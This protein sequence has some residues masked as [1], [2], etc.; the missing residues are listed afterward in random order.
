MANALNTVNS[1]GIKDGEVKTA[2]ILDA[3]VTTAKLAGDAVTGAKIADDAIDSE[4]IK[5][6]AVDLAHMSSESVDEDNLH[7]SNAGSNGQY[8]QKQTGNSGG[9][10]W[11]T[12]DTSTLMPLAGGTFT[13]DVTFD[14]G[15]N[16]GKDITWDESDDALEFADSTKASFGAGNDLV[17]QHDGTNNYIDTNTGA[18][19]IRSIGSA[20][21]VQI[22]ADSDYMA[23][24]VNDGEV[25]LYHDNEAKIVTKA[26]GAIVQDL[27]ASGAYLDIKGSDGV[28]GKVY[29]VSGTTVGL[30]DDQNHY[31]IKGVKDGA[32]SLYYD[33]SVKLAT[34]S[35][36]GTL[37]GT[38]SGVGKILQVVTAEHSATTS[39]TGT[40]YVDTGLTADITP[41]SS[42]NKIMVI[43]SQSWYLDRGTDQAR[44]G[45]RLVR[46]STVI[47]EGPNQG[48]GSA[49]GGFGVSTAN[50]PSAIQTAGR[51]NLTMV[52]SPSTTSEITYHTEMANHQTGSSPTLTINKSL[53]NNGQ[54]GK[55]YIT[56]LEIAG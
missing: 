28:N 42:S 56:L 54:N 9:L 51:Y 12:V 19:N 32:T 3:N 6:G 38:W 30:L 37:T 27:T 45:I 14:N 35:A 10:T 44:G 26:N 46:E 11:A 18:L 29:G 52:D 17:I 2:D 23:R 49:G 8:L 20:A 36:G 5:D 22:I 4:H 53:G 13:G 21:N 24:F 41:A 25:E 40:A 16:A 48:D 55:G 39:T 15:T 47:E 31:H 33:N 1:L 7:I 34:S 43:V 50:G